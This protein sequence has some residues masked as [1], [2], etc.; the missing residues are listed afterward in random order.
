[1]KLII[2]YFFLTDVLFLGGIKIWINTFFPLADVFFG[3][4]LRL[5]LSCIRVNTVYAGHKKE[6]E[7]NSMS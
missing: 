5:E 6:Q 3:G 4:R 2:K 1:V 7:Y